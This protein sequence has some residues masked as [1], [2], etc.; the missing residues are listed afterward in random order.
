EARLG[1]VE[2]DVALALQHVRG[3]EPGDTR[4]NHRDAPTLLRGG[5][6]HEETSPVTS[7]HPAARASSSGRSNGA[8]SAIAAVNAAVSRCHV[9]ARDNMTWPLHGKC[10]HRARRATGTA[11]VTNRADARG[12]VVRSR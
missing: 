12:L 1:F 7:R 11:R 2:G 8:S 5:G 3:G 9:D 4:P 6:V 10:R